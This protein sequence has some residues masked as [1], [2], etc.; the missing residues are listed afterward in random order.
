MPRITAALVRAPGL[1]AQGSGSSSMAPPASQ[2]IGAS[3]TGARRGGG[4]HVF[5]RTRAAGG[6]LG[7]LLRA[8]RTS[9]RV[10]QGTTAPHY[11]FVARGI[12]EALHPAVRAPPTCTHTVAR[13]RARCSRFDADAG[14]L[15][16]SDHGELV[17]DWVELF[18]PVVF[19][20]HRPKPLVDRGFAAVG[21]LRFG[22]DKRA[23][24]A[25]PPADRLRRLLRRRL[26]P[27]RAEALER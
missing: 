24:S 17:A 2:G 7:R 21:H 1:S 12:V 26:A 13:D 6:V 15:R 10:T 14:E 27:R 5:T 18:A 25:S 16:A 19:D 9:R 8:G 20:G 4:R 3:A 23:G 22:S 11:L